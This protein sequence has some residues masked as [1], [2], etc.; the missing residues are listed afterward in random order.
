[1][2]TFLC[3]LTETFI[4][5]LIRGQ[6]RRRAGGGRWRAAAMR[7]TSRESELR[8]MILRSMGRGLEMD[9]QMIES[10]GDCKVTRP[11]PVATRHLRQP[12]T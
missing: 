3:T 5:F 6:V 4:L 8:H 1:M 10:K 2:D 7:A 11:T 9:Q 12:Y